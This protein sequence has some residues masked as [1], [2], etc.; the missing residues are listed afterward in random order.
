MR[1]LS[2]SAP[3][4]CHDLLRLTRTLVACIRVADLIIGVD[5]QLG[6]GSRHRRDDDEGVSTLATSLKAAASEHVVGI[7]ETMTKS[8]DIEM[9]ETEKKI[10]FRS[11]ADGRL[12]ELNRLLQAWPEHLDRV[13]AE[14]RGE[15]PDFVADGNVVYL[16]QIGFLIQLPKSECENGDVEMREAQVELMFR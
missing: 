16:P 14:H 3:A 4:S 6:A 15:L 9:M 7:A 12:D 8:L 5:Q 1:K 2:T 11:G 10:A 13:V